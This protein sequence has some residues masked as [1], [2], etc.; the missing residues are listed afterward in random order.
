MGVSV[1]LNGCFFVIQTAFFATL[2]LLV[3]CSKYKTSDE[4]AYRGNN[5]Q[6]NNNFL[7][8]LKIW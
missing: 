2:F 7:H 8:Q 1:K 6:Y 5:N 4:V 3:L